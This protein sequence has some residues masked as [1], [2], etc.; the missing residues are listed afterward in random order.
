M[1][2]NPVFN[3]EALNLN[4][5]GKKLGFLSTTKGYRANVPGGWLVFIWDSGGM[6]GVTF[7]PDTNHEWDGGTEDRKATV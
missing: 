7:Y 4:V 5:E 2:N 3:L 1:K 6:S